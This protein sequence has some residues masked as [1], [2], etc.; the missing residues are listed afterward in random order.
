MD[1]YKLLNHSKKNGEGDTFNPYAAKTKQGSWIDGTIS[2][3]F[4]NKYFSQYETAEE[5][6]DATESEGLK[7][8]FGWL[9]EQGIL[10]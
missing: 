5:M 4:L 1:F 2:I 3:E 6:I 10:D 8:Y 9:K 7:L